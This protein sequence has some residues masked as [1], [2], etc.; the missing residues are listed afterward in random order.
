MSVP[1]AA[2]TG[3]QA[4]ASTPVAEQPPAPTGRTRALLAGFAG[5]HFSHHVSNSLLNPLLP[6]I[7]DSF[8]L[9]YSEAGLLV[10]AFSWSI[11]LSNAP[12]GFL[13]DRVGALRVVVGGLLLTGLLGA[14]LAFSGAYWQLLALIV[15]LGIVAATYHAPAASMI[16]AAFPSNVR[17]S[18][19]G[20]H[21]TGGNLSFF[22]TPLIAGSLLAAGGTWQTPFLWFA[23]APILAG[24]LIWL[25]A[26]PALRVGGGRA[27][28]G[29]FAVFRE[30]WGVARL[31]GP[32]VSASIVF[33]MVY[34]AFVAFVTLYLVDVKGI[35]VPLA[36]ALF[37]V[38]QL[39]GVFLAPLSG[40]LSDR[41]GRRSVMVLGMALL[42]PSLYSL[43]LVPAEL[44]VVPLAIIGVAASMRQTVTEVLVM[45]SAP[46]HRRATVLGSYYM[47]SQ[48]L[49]G[50]AAPVL[51]FTAG[52]VGL[53]SAFTGATVLLMAL[54]AIVL[55]VHRRL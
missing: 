45:D 43:T 1:G 42:G 51:G 2:M 24:L 4:A 48:E 5:A 36:A 19:M 18:A 30:V 22:A 29:R 27:G 31:V 6:P 50:F 21:V 53:A 34:A 7:R 37:G 47:L 17:G 25:V 9:G 3:G 11:G 20:L 54:S 46:E 23:W 52:I 32:L 38:P 10:S 14:A 39:I 15:L 49:G 33:Q 28:A 41:W 16:A 55:V 40:Y 8:G 35:S 44:V 26:P 13:A 12:I